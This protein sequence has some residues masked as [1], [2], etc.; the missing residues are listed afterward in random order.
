MFDFS[1]DGVR[2]SL[3]ESLVRL[4]LDR[5]DTVLIHDPDAHLE[6]A[7][8]EAYPAL[9]QLRAEGVVGTIG[10]GMNESEALVRFV[11]ETD[12]DCVL[13]AG[14]YTLL[15]GG[16]ADELLPL[17]E[18]RGCAVLAAGVFN[19]GILAGRR[20]RHLR[21]RIAVALAHC[22]RTQPPG[23]VRAVGGSAQ[24]RGVAVPA[25]A[26]SRHVSRRRLPL[27]GRG[28]GGSAALRSS[29]CPAGLWQELA[30]RGLLP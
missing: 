21:L 14:R 18:A 17:C 13:V 25:Q 10:A 28:R 3:E 19:S 1:P 15:D 9:E 11:R 20:Q 26:P 12:V 29:S 5:V 8:T 23:G 7:L 4:G 6:Q 27:G 30:E 22:P 2:R 24:G 16:V